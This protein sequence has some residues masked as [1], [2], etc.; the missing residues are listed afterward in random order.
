MWNYLYIIFLPRA[1]NK[2]FYCIEQLNENLISGFG[3]Y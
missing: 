3:K 2:Y 1:I